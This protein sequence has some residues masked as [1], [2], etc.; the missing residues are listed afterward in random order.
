MLFEMGVMQKFVLFL[1]SP[2][3]SMAVIIPV[4]LAGAGLGSLYAQ[5]RDISRPWFA[6]GAAA[7]CGLL[8]C[9]LNL[10]IPAVSARLLTQ[11][12]PLRIIVVIII[13]APLSF[14]MGFPFPLGLRAAGKYD[15]G[16]VPWAWAINGAASVIASVMAIIIAMAFGFKMVIGISAACYFIAALAV[17]F[18]LRYRLPEIR[19]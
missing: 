4:L 17:V 12:L 18:F 14:C 16:Y 2:I 3:Y 13:L 10:L 11:P 15:R 5:R 8:I 6:A 19:G 1:G 7:V 9:A